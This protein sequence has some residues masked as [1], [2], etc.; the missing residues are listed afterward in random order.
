M[1]FKIDK[2]D[3]LNKGFC[4]IKNLLNKDEVTYY[5]EKIKKLANNSNHFLLGGIYN[6]R[7]FQI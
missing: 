5:D 6:E 4:V 3:F 7:K 1:D 2:Q